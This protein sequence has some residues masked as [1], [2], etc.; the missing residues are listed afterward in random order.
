MEREELMHQS[1]TITAASLYCFVLRLL[2]L[3]IGFG[4]ADSTSGD[5]IYWTGVSEDKIKRAFPDGTEIEELVDLGGGNPAGIAVDAVGGKVY[6]T[7]ILQ[8]QIMR[9]NLD[10]TV[11]QELINGL[12][13]PGGLA[14]D[15]ATQKIYWTEN[16][17][18]TNRISRANL[19][20]TGIEI[21]IPEATGNPAGIA[22]DVENGKMYWADWGGTE[23]IRRAN[24]D[25]TEIEDLITVG[26]SRPVD[27][28]LDVAAGKLYWVDL[29]G[30]AI[31]VANL[32]GSG[33]HILISMK[34]SD[35]RPAALA[36]DPQAGMIF[37]MESF[38]ILGRIRRARLDGT[39]LRRVVVSEV[40]NSSGVALDISDCND[41]G[42]SDYYELEVG[43]SPDCNVNHVPD[44]CDIS[45]GTSDDCNGNLVPD[46][47]DVPHQFHATSPQLS[48]LGGLVSASFT[49]FSAAEAL[50]D[51][52]LTI[53][54]HADLNEST[55]WIDV[56]IN[57]IDVGRVFAERAEFCPSEPDC[58]ELIVPAE[59]FNG[60][61][62]GGD[63]VINL[64]PSLSVNPGNCNDRSF[65]TITVEYDTQGTT[66]DCN[67]NG[68]P[69]ECINL[70]DDC[71]ANQVPDVCDIADG[72]SEDC[73][74]NSIPDECIDLEDDCNA[75]QV[76]DVCDIADGTSEDC[77]AN[78]VPDEC[79]IAQGASE[80]CNANAA[81]DECDIAGGSS[82]D[83]DDSAVPD[84]CEEVGPL[85][86]DQPMS[87][88]VDEGSL[89]AFTVVA[90]GLLLEYQW[91]KD[92]GDLTDTESI[93]GSTAMTLFILDVQVGDAGEYDCV[94]TDAFGCSETSEVA[95]LTVNVACP[96]DLDGD[97]SVGPIDL[98]I[99]LGGWGS[100]PGHPADFDEDGVV[101]PI[102]LATLLGAWGPCP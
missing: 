53:R 62:D 18:F 35:Y 16:T 37:W 50:S 54:A 92:G 31:G 63:T 1:R 95:V 28:A 80:D 93:I 79:D 91:R 24:L 85:I 98:A 70:E 39:D 90:D 56:D 33:A 59:L 87:Q 9:S 7:V 22:L 14:L 25:G 44:S 51:V 82:S 57:G 99:L 88:E 96:A 97:G 84:E 21:L 81:P 67:A 45:R 43:S 4:W 61:V 3:P 102:D 69:D 77:N 49:L 60:A 94:V 47:C 41:N 20:G 72:T 2:L 10:G 48:P 19:N 68:I 52:S 73:N 11:V 101:G 66:A 8:D 78:G 6:W 71:N 34:D 74:A 65:A 30:E 17:T 100:N 5:G 64:T 38:S 75:N 23:K 55:E 27:I 89:A 40:S 36:L 58:A 13:S 42:T 46:A 32:D 12:N 26:L 15:L 29:F 86:I 76:P 83:C